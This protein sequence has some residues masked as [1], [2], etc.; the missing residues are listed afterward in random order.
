VL[1]DPQDAYTKE[2][3]TAISHPPLPVRK[4]VE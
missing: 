3:L 4:Q 2:L 1:G